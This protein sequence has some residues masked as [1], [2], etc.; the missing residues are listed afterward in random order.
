MKRILTLLSFVVIGTGSLH[1]SA[2]VPTIKIVPMSQELRDQGASENTFVFEDFPLNQE[3]NLCYTKVVKVDPKS[4][5]KMDIIS[6]DENGLM[7]L[8]RGDKYLFYAV[9]SVGM[10][11]GERVTYRCVLPDRTILAE[12]SYIPHP[13]HRES[14]DKT[15]SV[16][17]ELISLA[18]LTIYSIKYS[19]LNENE[20]IHLISI[21]GKETIE[22]DLYHHKDDSHNYLPGV[23]GKTGGTSTLEATR[24]T[25]DKL[26]L[27]L[28]WG[29]AVLTETLKSLN[30]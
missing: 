29:D 18:P 4:Y 20:K 15:F 25:G 26:K 30:Q 28:K 9:D 23:N 19:G 11:N 17:A 22:S 12:T 27:Q 24:S 3:F 1:L 2:G 5:T 13:I 6:L 14:R 10:A 21:S 7:R 16:D 8:N